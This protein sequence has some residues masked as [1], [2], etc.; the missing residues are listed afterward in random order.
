MGR[1]DSRGRGGRQRPAGRGR[2]G[3]PQQNNKQHK[4]ENDDHG[5]DELD[6]EV[7]DFFTDLTGR[8]PMK[9]AKLEDH[10]NAAEGAMQV[11]TD[12]QETPFLLGDSLPSGKGQGSEQTQDV[13]SWL[14]LGLCKAV[15]KKV[16]ANAQ[17][18]KSGANYYFAPTPV[19]AKAIP[20]IVEGKD[21]CV[22]AVTGSGKTAA[23][24]LPLLH[25]LLVCK[26]PANRKRY[27]RS[28]ILV[29]TRELGVQCEAMIQRFLPQPTLKRD[30]EG[31]TPE[32]EEGIK[33]AL[34][35]G[36]VAAHTQEALLDAGPDI[37]IATP[38]RLVDFLFNYKK[39]RLVNKNKVRDDDAYQTK[40][41]VAVKGPTM[42]TCT[43]IKKD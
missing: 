41:K 42:I 23:Y 35:I 26:P 27:I 30:S 18:D 31:K 10:Q 19:Q 15:L 24:L 22:R 16:N 17:L 1:P 34:A 2:G 7:Q 32:D 12:P 39:H 33:V 40:K 25:R 13:V 43:E 28:V 36:G 21:V 3:K 14:Q 9:S 29:P 38:G 11:F 8:R 5:N 20:A 4:K 37:L 6:M